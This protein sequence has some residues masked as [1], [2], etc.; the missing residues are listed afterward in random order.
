VGPARSSSAERLQLAWSQ[1]RSQFGKDYN[2]RLFTGLL[3][4][5]VA[6][7]VIFRWELLFVICNII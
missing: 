5:A 7:I 2:D 1:A 3:V 4:A 6:A